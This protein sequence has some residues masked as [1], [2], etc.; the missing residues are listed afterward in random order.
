MKNLKKLVYQYKYLKMDLDE[1]KEQHSELTI[2][3]EK[4]FSNI[5]KRDGN[6]EKDVPIEEG[7]NK[8]IQAD[9]IGR[10]YV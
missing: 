6:I 4:E 8:T 7:K 9:E 2:S 3:F 1:L 5:I 10:A